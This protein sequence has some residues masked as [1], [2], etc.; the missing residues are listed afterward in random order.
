MNLQMPSPTIAA[1][2]VNKQVFGKPAD[3]ADAFRG[4]EKAHH[5][6]IRLTHTGI[7]VRSRGAGTV[8]YKDGDPRATTSGKAKGAEQCAAQR[9]YGVKFVHWADK[10]LPC[11]EVK[12]MLAEI[13]GGR[14]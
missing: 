2:A 9:I 11:P 1:L 7:E 14:L 3:V 12:T 13:N 6:D 10:N 8:L 4:I 5:V